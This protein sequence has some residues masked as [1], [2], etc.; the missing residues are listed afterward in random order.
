MVAPLS[1]A[2]QAIKSHSRTRRWLSRWSPKIRTCLRRFGPFA[3]RLQK[4]AARQSGRYEPWSRTRRKSCCPTARLT[5]TGS[6][7]HWAIASEPSRADW[8]TKT[9]PTRRSWINCG[10]ASRF[11]TSRSRAYRFPKSRGCSATKDRPPLTTPSN[12]GQGSRLL[13]LAIRSSFPRQDKAFSRA[14]L[15]RRPQKAEDWPT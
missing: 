7:R 2:H 14:N 11:N 1:L 15:P 13:L 8:L 4:S 6:P 9:R 3:M 10:E 5:D 12:V